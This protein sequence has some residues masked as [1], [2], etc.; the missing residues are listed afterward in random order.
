MRLFA[1]VLVAALSSVLRA[2]LDTEM[3]YLTVSVTGV[4]NA[5]VPGIEKERF[6]VFEDGVEQEIAYF[7]E[8]SRPITVGF[9]FDD[10]APMAI[11]DK[12]YALEEAAQAFL[13][14]KDPK[15]EYFVVTVRD[16]P[17]V[18]VS[19][20][21]DADKLPAVYGAMGDTSLYD[22]I[23]MGLSVIKEAANP[24]KVLV[25]ITSGG[26]PLRTSGEA[27]EAFALKQP[28]QI[29]SL[30]MM[31]I[32]KNQ[33]GA[34]VI[35]R[36]ANLLN[37]LATMTGGRFYNSQIAARAV[38]T[39]MAEVAR[40]LKTQY[41]IGYKSPRPNHDGKRRGVKVKVSS[42]EGSPKLDVWTKSGYYR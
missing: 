16:T 14:A 22:S 20:T 17:V 32:G 18:L 27:L 11:D 13:R 21:T 3:V 42:P 35:L 1:V 37:D 8:D 39:L 36:D 25:V 12:Y 4:R 29:Y 28:V 40:G 24:R 31:A 7:Y 15:D 5:A 30:F 19:F 10:S 23:Y 9:I 41:L 2:Q 33:T 38:E 26:D 34:E 6:H